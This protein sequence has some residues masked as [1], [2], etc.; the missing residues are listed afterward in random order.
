ARCYVGALVDV[1]LPHAEGVALLARDVGEQAFHPARR[2][3]AARREEHEHR[4]GVLGHEITTAQSRSRVRWLR[5]AR[6]TGSASASVS[7]Q[8]RGGASRGSA[9]AS[10]RA[11]APLGPRPRPFWGSRW[12]PAHRGAGGACVAG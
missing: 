3:R 10:R 9:L 7:A 8:R 6:G 2:P 4:E 1:H 5:W 11:R 12:A